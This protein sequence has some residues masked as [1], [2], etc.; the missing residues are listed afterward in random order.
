MRRVRQ[1]PRAQ[2]SVQATVQVSAPVEG[3]IVDLSSCGLRLA[4]KPEDVLEKGQALRLQFV[5]NV[6]DKAHHIDIVATVVSL[7]GP[8]D[9]RHP[10]VQFYGLT[11]IPGS[12]FEQMLLHAY[13]H[14]RLVDELDAT[15]KVL[16]GANEPAAS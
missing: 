2:V 8:A 3:V 5:I 4:M 11:I 13:V 1:R 14:E 10:T 15:W 6:L 9:S 12:D 16:A 7:Y